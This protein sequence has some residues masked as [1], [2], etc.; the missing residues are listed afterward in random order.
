MSRQYDIN[1][2]NVTV[3]L[4][5][6]LSSVLGVAGKVLRLVRARVGMTNTAIATAQGLQLRV[7]M[8]TATL[9]LGSGGTAA[10]PR[11]LDPGDTAEAGTARVND[12]TKATTSG[13]FTILEETGVHIY[14]GYDYTWPSDARPSIGGAGGFVFELLSTVSGAVALSGGIRVEEIG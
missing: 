12:T 11:P 8:A 3:T 2:E 1:F 4:P 9:T 6:D 7:R 13:A 14:T 10:T 5:Q